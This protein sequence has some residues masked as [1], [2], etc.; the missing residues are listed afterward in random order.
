MYRFWRG[1]IIG[2][3]VSHVWA[4]FAPCI[5]LEFGELTSEGTYTDRQGQVQ[6]F[7]PRGVWSITSMDSWPDWR[8]RQNGRLIVSCEECRPRRLRAL[9]LLLGRR[10]NALEI[11]GRSKSTRLT[12]S[13]GLALET[14][15][16]IRRLRRAPHWMLRGP[17]QGDDDWPCIELGR[18]PPFARTRQATTL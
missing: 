11:D 14:R 6:E 8:L 7:E 5:F 4:S 18:N 16:V 2:L 9:R 13:L 17:S 10:L 15:T 3:N 12:F 1:P